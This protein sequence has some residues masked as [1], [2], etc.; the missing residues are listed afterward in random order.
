M[1]G[2]ELID[3]LWKS[4][5]HEQLSGSLRSGSNFRYRYNAGSIVL[6]GKAEPAW[7]EETESPLAVSMIAIRLF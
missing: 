3:F 1:S 7:I 2:S 6:N 5:C 4:N